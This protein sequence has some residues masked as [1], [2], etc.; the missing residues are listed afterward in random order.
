MTK[1][2]DESYSPE[3]RTALVL[4]G[5]GT[6]GA[7]HAG[8]L[9]A[10]HEAGVKL[11]VVAG[12]GVGAVGALFAA[13]DGAERL[14]GDKGFWRAPAV[15]TL[16]SWRPPVRL[17]SAALAVSVALVVL[18]LAVMA[19]GLVVFPIDFLLKMLGVTGEAGLV[20]R[21][22][23]FADAMFAPSALPTWLPR[24]V[25]LVLASAALIAAAS[26]WGQ[27]D[28]RRRRGPFWWRVLRPPLGTAAAVDHCWATLWDL[29][30][31]A[32]QLRQP[33]RL[34]LGRRYVEL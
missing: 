28:Q 6:S 18:P 26:A 9:R 19:A 29:V 21:Y 2:R 12:R 15:K 17:A 8:V 5:V 23:E 16:Y 4:S 33:T 3:R 13:V 7:Y 25:L 34:D 22:M 32:A 27:R 11:D 30:R 14:W 31:G 20:P 10:L 24:L 1:S